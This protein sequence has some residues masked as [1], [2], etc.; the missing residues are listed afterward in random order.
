MVETVVTAK[1]SNDHFVGGVLMVLSAISY[2]TAGF[3]T[4]LISTDLW[5]MLCL[6]GFFASAFLLIYLL[7]MFGGEQRRS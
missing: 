7:Y 3:F 6:R 2:S 1:T 5:T 4:R